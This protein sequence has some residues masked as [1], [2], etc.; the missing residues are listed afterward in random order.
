MVIATVAFL[1]LA[2][3][4]ASSVSVSI[5]PTKTRDVINPYIYGQF[6]EHLG[7]CIYGGIWAEMLEDRKFFHPIKATYAPYV[8]MKDT[9]FPGIGA[10]P[11]EINTGKVEM[12][13]QDVFVGRHTPVLADGT[14]IS[15]HRL[16]TLAG[17]EY[18]GYIWLK[19]LAGT[20]K[21]SVSFG[22]ET[23]TIS[24]KPWTCRP[25]TS[26]FTIT[27]QWIFL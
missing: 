27:V 10:S 18:I 26:G 12:S 22:S 6:I 2:M 9:D 11:W 15:Q 4:D 7:R 5:D 19:P 16:G 21:V 1:S 17:K 23:T 25:T 13:K 20:P 24:P 14:K 3:Q 8:S